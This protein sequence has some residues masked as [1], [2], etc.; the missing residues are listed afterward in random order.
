MLTFRLARSLGSETRFQYC[1]NSCNKLLTELRAV[2]GHTGGDMIRPEM[3]GHVLIP[4]CW[5]EFVF[6]RGFSFN[7]TSILDAGLIAG[8]RQGRE[9]RRTVF[10]TPLNPRGTEEEQEYCDDLTKARKVYYKTGWKHSENAVYWIHLGRAQERG[11]AFWQSKSHAIITNSTTPLDCIE[12]VISQR[13]EMTVHERS[14][15]P[16]PA[17]RIVLTTAWCEQQ[18]EVVLRSR[19]NCNRTHKKR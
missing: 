13:G 12:R 5:K 16:S 17:P 7:V 2:Q 18:Q 4:P 9:T 15:T 8:G 3:L 14:S 19:G 11:I 10:F 6:H 1:Q